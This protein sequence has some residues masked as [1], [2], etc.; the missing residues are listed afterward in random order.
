MR[1]SFTILLLLNVSVLH[2]SDSRADE[3]AVERKVGCSN[4]KFVEAEE[5][6]YK[7]LLSNRAE[8]E[9]RQMDRITAIESE[10]KTGLDKA[11]DKYQRALQASGNV[12]VL[13]EQAKATYDN[14]TS[15]ALQGRDDKLKTLSKIAAKS[16]G[17]AQD[18]YDEAVKE[19]AKLYC[20]SYKATGKT[21][22]VV[23][24]GTIVSLDKPFT[25][26]GTGPPLKGLGA[27]TYDF[28]FVPA[29]GK[30]GASGMMTYG[31]K[32]VLSA[33]GGGPYTVEGLDTDKPRIVVQ[34]KSTAT[35]K[36]KI[37]ASGGGTSQIDLVPIKLN[38]NSTKEN[39]K[40]AP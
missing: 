28:M 18:D 33:A 19:A 9:Q 8:V 13:N 38:E 20:H 6:A 26:K 32:G 5:K 12:T 27:L 16:Y 37:T 7:D 23:Y 4:P 31:L 39:T 14:E 35:F 21:H 24:S 25:V 17:D 10:K 15:S 36:G 1:I 29:A 40:A 30:N 34:S 3:F 11:N 2:P 22:D